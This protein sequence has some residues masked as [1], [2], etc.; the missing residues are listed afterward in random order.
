MSHP[1]RSVCRILTK[2]ALHLKVL[3]QRCKVPGRQR[4]VLSAPCL[5]LAVGEADTVDNVQK[6]GRVVVI[7]IVTA[8]AV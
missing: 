2:A 8:Q 1:R 7:P 3:R 6:Q 5:S 4:G